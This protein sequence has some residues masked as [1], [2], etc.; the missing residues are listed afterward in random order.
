MKSRNTWSNRQIWPWST[1]WCRAKANRVLP[2]ERTGHSKHLLPTIQKKTL[3]K[4]ITRWS[5]LESDW[6]YFVAK[7]GEA[8]CSQW[9]QDWELTVAQ[10]M[11]SLVPNSDVNGR[12][13]NFWL[14]RAN[15]GTGL[16]QWLSG[17]ESACSAEGAGSLPRLG[18]S[19]GKGNGNLLHYSCLG[20]P[21]GKGA[22]Q[23]TV[24][25]VTRVRHD[26]AAKPPPAIMGYWTPPGI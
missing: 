18:R 14:M 24:P 4:N 16:P 2:I 10:I 15:H 22:W 8:L 7:D 20:K 21:M 19:P 11:N 6:L 3:P 1:E 23:A 25:G 13:W 5:I 17:K 12:K 26:L 9:K